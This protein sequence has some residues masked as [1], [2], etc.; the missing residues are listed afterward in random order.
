MAQDIEEIHHYNSNNTDNVDFV[1]KSNVI[2]NNISNPSN[3]IPETKTI[4]IKTWGCSHNISDSEYMSGLLSSFGYNII[5]NEDKSD[6]ADLWLLNSC[7]VK[8]P[9]QEHFISFVKKGK[10]KGKLIIAAGCVP[11]GDKKLNIINNISIIGVQQIDRV[12]DVVKETFR[13]NIVKLFNEKK[14]QNIDGK[15]KRKDGGAKL[16]LPKIRKNK[17]IE[18]IPINTGCLNQC[19]YCKTKHAR[20]DL[21][22]YTINEILNRIKYVINEGIIREI[23]LTSEDTGAY[24]IDIGTSIDILLNEIC[25]VLNDPQY[26][27]KIMIR[28]GMSNPPYIMQ[29]LK[30]LS[31][32]LNHP[33]IYSFL[34]IPVQSGSNRILYKMKR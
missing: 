21:G 2:K 17:L 5:L 20:G 12:V 9:S 24:G 13:G 7:T 6:D 1:D 29:H 31:L 32:A 15:N 18:I 8:G 10:L 19:T 25:N 34:H 3:I 27:N 26:F 33:N 14:I 23:W 16:N 28:L 11:Q 30:S 22:S 4:Y